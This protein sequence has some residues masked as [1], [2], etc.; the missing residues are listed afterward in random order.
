MK[1]KNYKTTIAG[2]LAALAIIFVNVSAALDEDPNT[3]ISIEQLVGGAVTA[4]SILGVGYFA[5]DAEKPAEKPNDD[6]PA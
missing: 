1:P 5:K 6:G 2:L 4:L 3:K